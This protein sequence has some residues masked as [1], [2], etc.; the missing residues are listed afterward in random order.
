MQ[1]ISSST[2][3][4]IIPVLN[5]TK[6]TRFVDSSPG[7]KYWYFLLWP[8]GKKNICNNL[9]IGN[10]AWICILSWDW[11]ENCQYPN[12]NNTIIIFLSTSNFLKSASVLVKYEY[13]NLHYL[14]TV[15]WSISANSAT[16][17]PFRMCRVSWGVEGGPGADCVGTAVAHLVLQVPH[18]R[19]SLARRVHGQVSNGNAGIR[20]CARLARVRTWV[21]RMGLGSDSH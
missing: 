8:G 15:L 16:S 18:L 12:K 5:H 11:L 19:H 7:L 2:M 4:H 10:T 14:G 3:Y 13:S 9:R 17:V 20:Q 21:I 1:W 6:I